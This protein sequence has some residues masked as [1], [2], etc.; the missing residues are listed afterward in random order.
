MKNK[1]TL[2]CIFCLLAA[3][4]WGLSFVAQSVGNSMGPFTFNAARSIVAFAAL[5]PFAIYATKKQAKKQ[6]ESLKTAYANLFKAGI[7]CSICFVLAENFQQYA[8]NF[9]ESGRVGF[10]TAFYMI[11]VP[12]MSVIMGK[13]VKAN[14]WIGVLLGLLGL[15]FLSVKQGSFAAGKGE[16]IAFAC[17]FFFAVHIMVI[18]RTC[19]TVNPIALNCFQ[20]LVS[21]VVTSA[22]MLLFEKPEIYQIK[23]GLLPIIYTGLF[24][25]G[26]GYTFQMF[27]QKYANPTAASL[28]LCFESV[29]SVIFGRLIL[30]ENLGARSLAGCAIMF[31]GII[32]TQIEFKRRKQK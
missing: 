16:L 1:K 13:K 11:F 20:F 30:K 5:L 26:L 31:N 6:N 17:S 22:L 19:Q 25:C 8:F 18:D 2:G 7:P 28:L 24:S 9:I 12:V 10:I 32:L 27:G 21:S 4:V 15:Y 29:F 23:Q 14:A 3:L